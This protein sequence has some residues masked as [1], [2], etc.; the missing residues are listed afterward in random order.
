VDVVVR[1]E[2]TGYQVDHYRATCRFGRSP[3]APVKRLDLTLCAC[4]RLPLNPQSDLY[5]GLLFH[6]GRFCRLLGYRRLNAL[7]C[8]A[9]ISPG[10][11]SAWFGPYLPADLLL[12]DPAE[13]DAAIH[14]IQAC[15][16]HAR[17]LPTGIDRLSIQTIS[18]GSAKWVWAKE[19]QRQGDH[20]IY[21]VTV[22]NIDGQVLEEWE[23]LRL[24]AVGNIPPPTSW[25]EP[26]VV[27]YIERRLQELLPAAP[28]AVALERNANL[29][30][31]A[32]SDLAIHHALGARVPI[33]KRPDG[34]PDVNG[35]ASVS[36]AHSGDITL[37]V[38]GQGSLG[39]DLET[40]A[41]RPLS[42]W[43]DLVGRERVG[44]AERIADEMAE[45]LQLAATRIWV[46][47][48]CLK[49]AGAS[50]AM[51][52]TLDSVHADGWLFLQAGTMAVA[53][54]VAALSGET[55]RFV[56]GIALEK[57]PVRENDLG[58]VVLTSREKSL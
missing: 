42:V 57:S 8:V 37:A 5:G 18:S 4:E 30:R 10:D 48:E 50:V 14:A 38:S 56:F 45:D 34:K 58:M 35:S 20:F 15:I 43:Q 27:P 54:W 28:V 46:A 31:P 11:P 19:R 52:L 9:E 2:E 13:R 23:G 1:S 7:E 41:D 51:P 40:V 6:S 49:K 55:K 26:L 3:A 36:A 39:C 44:L 25:I 29:P 22:T 24:R 12:G 47:I 32:R 16:P 21:D 17:I 53:T 33:W